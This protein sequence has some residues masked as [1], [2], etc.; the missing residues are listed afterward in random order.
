MKK[1][2]AGN[3]FVVAEEAFVEPE[4]WLQNVEAARVV[5]R[6]FDK[7]RRRRYRRRY[8]DGD[9]D[10]DSPVSTFFDLGPDRLGRFENDVG[11]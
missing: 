2:E 1:D 5:G 8:G 10:E 7:K 9:A 11:E 6:K 3:L 4:I